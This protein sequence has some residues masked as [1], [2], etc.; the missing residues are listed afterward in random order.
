[1]TEHHDIGWAMRHAR[2]G[3]KVCRQAWR[4]ASLFL[5]HGALMMRRADNVTQLWVVNQADLF[6]DDWELAV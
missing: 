2:K 3:Q 5:D 6:M 4:G 1:M